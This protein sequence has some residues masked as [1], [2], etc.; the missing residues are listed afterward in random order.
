MYR[1]CGGKGAVSDSEWPQSEGMVGRE[2]LNTRLISLWSCIYPSIT[3]MLLPLPGAF[4]CLTGVSTNQ[5]CD[6]VLSNDRDNV[7]ARKLVG[8]IAP[9][10]ALSVRATLRGRSIYDVIL[11]SSWDDV[12]QQ[13][14][15]CGDGS[16]CRCGAIDSGLAEC[17]SARLNKSA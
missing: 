12:L 17:V 13:P 3:M 5:S 16:S 6:P 8:G 2:G 15:R 14:I 1:F 4:P 10:Q 7:R 9:D 11:L